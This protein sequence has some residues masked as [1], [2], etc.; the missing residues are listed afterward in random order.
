MHDSNDQ[1]KI[2]P[3]TVDNDPHEQQHPAGKAYKKINLVVCIVVSMMEKRCDK[4]TFVGD[5]AAL[6][7]HRKRKTPCDSG[8]HLCRKGCGKGLK[9]PETRRNHEKTRE[10]L[11]MHNTTLQAQLT[12][13]VEVSNLRMAVASRAT[14]SA[15]K[16]VGGIIICCGSLGGLVR[17]A[18]KTISLAC[19]CLA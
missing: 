3:T 11:Q 6:E 16:G 15:V 7:Q 1:Y 13:Q 12:T 5:E 17:E 2:W 18:T 8:Q 10:E 14:A 9:S 19:L 4:C